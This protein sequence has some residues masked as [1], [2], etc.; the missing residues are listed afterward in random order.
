MGR[1]VLAD[2]YSVNFSLRLM[3]KDANL[4]A[5]FAERL[6]AP[7]PSTSATREQIKQAVDDGFGELNASALLK[8]IAERANVQLNN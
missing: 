1:G 5:G 8:S 4:I 7:I 6:G 2:D 3:L